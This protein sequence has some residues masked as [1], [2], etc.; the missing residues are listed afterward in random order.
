VRQ[1]DPV[2]LESGSEEQFYNARFLL[3]KAKQECF[4]WPG[5]QLLSE[6]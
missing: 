3:T 6:R 4:T 5:L 2:L 1:F